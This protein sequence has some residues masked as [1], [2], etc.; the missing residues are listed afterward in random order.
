L[1]YS[2]FAL[3]SIV[4]NIPTILALVVNG[5]F[6]ERVN[7]PVFGTYG[8]FNGL[9]NEYMMEIREF[10]IASSVYLGCG[11]LGLI[12][13]KLRDRRLVTIVL[14]LTLCG[15]VSKAAM[16]LWAIMK[17]YIGFLSSFQI[18]GFAYMAPFFAVVAAGYGVHSVLRLTLGWR[19]LKLPTKL[20]RRVFPV[21][22]ILW[23]I[24]AS[25]GIKVYHISGGVT[26]GDL[27]GSD[28]LQRLGAG[29]CG[30]PFRVATVAYQLDP[31][32]ANAYGL[33]TVDGYLSLYP[34]TY[35][36]FW[37]KVIE[38]LTSTDPA[39]Y[40]YFHN[41]G[42][43]IYLFPPSN[44][45]FNS[46]NAIPVSEYYN[47]NLL[48]LANTEYII[49]TKPLVG[50]GLTPIATGQLYVYRNEKCFPRFFLAQQLAVFQNSTKLL[51]AM[52]QASWATLRNTAFIEQEYA[53]IAREKLGFSVG[54]VT[55]DQY[56]TDKIVL[57]ID[58]DGP[59]ILV[60]TNN[61]SQYWKCNV[62]GMQREIVPV[63]HTFSGIYL[64]AGH[65]VVTFQYDPPYWSFY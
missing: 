14:L 16:P 10:L 61:Y 4:G 50:D 11:L 33:E 51:E 35:Q 26:Y 20:M 62:D 42:G 36:D 24:A 29:S 22:I 40:N 31:A 13:T 34:S 17:P 15:V 23:L 46:M 43:R 27:Y 41:W 3:V 21:L 7:W 63:Y 44:R 6:S 30:Y 54:N 60:V 5:P 53:S 32:F 39:I 47:L 59:G 19:R 2:T 9:L 18:D 45:S 38:P 49:A 65:H 28:V 52:S 37:G 8:S 56:S 48:S 1:I 25:L 55:R 64:E 58:L 57:T 12:L